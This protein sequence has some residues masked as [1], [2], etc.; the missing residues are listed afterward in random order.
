MLDGKRVKMMMKVKFMW[1]CL[2]GE[3]SL[4]PLQCHNGILCLVPFVSPFLPLLVL[5]F[6]SEPRKIEKGTCCVCVCVCIYWHILMIRWMDR[7]TDMQS[8]CKKWC[9][10]A[11]K[12]HHIEIVSQSNIK[13]MYDIFTFSCFG[14]EIVPPLTN[15]TH[16][17]TVLIGLLV[18]KQTR[19]LCRSPI[20]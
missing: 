9:S 14:D 11:M 20:S 8:S 2:A 13:A 17:L 7:W 10:P 18:Y 4:A 16:R 3:K 19:G 15:N 5:P 12:R 6:W 1:T